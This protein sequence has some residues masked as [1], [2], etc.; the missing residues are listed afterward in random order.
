MKKIGILTFHWADNYGAVLQAYALRTYLSQSGYNAEVVNYRCK[1]PARIYRPFYFQS[2]SV[3]QSIKGLLRCIY[4]FPDW[5]LKRYAFNKFRKNI[6]L[7]EHIYTKQ[8]L[9][10]EQYDYDVLIAGSDQVWN[11]EIVGDDIDIYSLSFVKKASAISYAAS[12]GKLDIQRNEID[13]RLVDSLARLDAISVREKSTKEYLKTNLGKPICLSADPTMLLTKNEWEQLSEGV[14]RVD[15]KYLF[16]YCISYDKHL[17]D[18][19]RKISREKNLKIVVCGKIKELKGESIQFT[20]A[21]PEQFLNLVKYANFIVATSYHATVFSTIFQK[22]FVV[23]LPSYAS[24]RVS[25]FCESFGLSN[26]CIH[27]ASEADALLEQE[28]VYDEIIHNKMD[29]VAESKYYLQKALEETQ[30][31]RE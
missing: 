21:S 6:G 4:N 7:S 3:S 8:E 1:Y 27:D 13:R 9:S 31:E 17:I 18:T 12:S 10:D 20:H 25:D 2:N 11:A 5:A 28:I 30:F 16:V 24:N 23:L 22:Q 29:I 26:R 15:G 19:V 14:H